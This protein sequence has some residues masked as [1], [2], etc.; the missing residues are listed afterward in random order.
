[1]LVRRHDWLGRHTKAESASDLGRKT[2]WLFKD[3]TAVEPVVIFDCC[4]CIRR[5]CSVSI[6]GDC[7][8][9]EQ[10]SNIARLRLASSIT[11]R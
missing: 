1:M 8:A 11:L 5:V 2:T 3:G 7:Q 4:I 10:G 9:D 6:A